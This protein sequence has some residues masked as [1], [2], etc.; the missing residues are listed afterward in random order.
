MNGFQKTG[1][2]P[3]D[4]EKVD[5]SKC[6][7]D[8]QVHEIADAEQLYQTDGYAVQP[9]RTGLRFLE[10]RI[11]YEKL[12]MFES[13]YVGEWLGDAED[14]SLFMLWSDVKDDIGSFH[15]T[16][17]GPLSA[18]ESLPDKNLSDENRPS[19]KCRPSFQ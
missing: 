7:K 16:H 6:I 18:V 5:Y 3:F 9:L 14:N 2:Y 10:Q 8:Q 17:P 15:L 1:L 11:G 4:Q 12:Q 19:D 13:A